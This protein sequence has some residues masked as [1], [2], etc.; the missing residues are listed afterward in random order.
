MPKKKSRKP[1]K[2]PLTAKNA[3]RHVLYQESVQ[4]TEN[5]AAFLARTFKKLRGRPAQSLREDFCGTALLC[6]EWV[7]KKDR[8]AMG[9]DLDPAVLAW[10][11]KHNLES[12]GEPGNRITLLQKDVR[13]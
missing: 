6:A 11:T 2:P 12:I 1:K 9:I 5:E 10:G 3:D 4:D 7:K 8:T 13:A